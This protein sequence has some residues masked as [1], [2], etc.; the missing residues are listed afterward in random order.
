L[1]TEIL[2]AL[3]P[4]ASTSLGV[5]PGIFNSQA[6]LKY[7][8]A[9]EADHE[10]EIIPYLLFDL[11]YYIQQETNPITATATELLDCEAASI[12]LYD[13]KNP[14]LFFAASTGSDPAKLAE[15][16][17]PIDSSLAGTIFRTNQPLILNR[18]GGKN[19]GSGLSF[20]TRADLE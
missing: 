9:I 13:E 14:R 16:P 6:A 15:I 19:G 11:S 20:F 3:T 8:Q 1:W 12:L 4:A 2:M 10:R 18:R 17:V 5:I 7:L